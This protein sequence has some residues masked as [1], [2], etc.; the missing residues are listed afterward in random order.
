MSGLRTTSVIS[1]TCRATAGGTGTS[2]RSTVSIQRAVVAA[3]SDS[4]SA[5][6]GASADERSADSSVSECPSWNQSTCTCRRVSATASPSVPRASRAPP[7][8]AS[9]WS[10]KRPVR[11]SRY[12]RMRVV[13][14]PQARLRKR[15]E[16][17]DERMRR[18]AHAHDPAQRQEPRELRRERRD[19]R[20]RQPARREAVLDFI[21]RRGVLDA[22]FRE[23][24]GARHAARIVD[25]AVHQHRHAFA[26]EQHRQQ[27]RE[28]RLLARAVVARDRYRSRVVAAV[29]DVQRLERA[30]AAASIAASSAAVSP[31]TRYAS[32]TAP[33]SRSETRPSSIA[34]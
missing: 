26:G 34:S 29:L 4:G 33:S 30:C 19:R 24:L 23:D 21:V 15:L 17:L 22:Q 27:R 12:S 14:E 20:E 8:A 11:L 31:F 5:T 2:P 13:H 25:D 3:S 6:A 7:V 1:S 18:I 10:M 9:G 28:V 16:N 32:S